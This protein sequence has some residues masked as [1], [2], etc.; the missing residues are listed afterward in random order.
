MDLHT[1]KYPRG[2]EPFSDHVTRCCVNGQI[3]RWGQRR[4]VSVYT[5]TREEENQQQRQKK[6]KNPEE[7]RFQE[8]LAQHRRDDRSVHIKVSSLDMKT[9]RRRFKPL[10]TVVAEFLEIL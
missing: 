6:K 8:F 5:R 4:D 9:R 10:S 7:K 3:H 1:H 2:K